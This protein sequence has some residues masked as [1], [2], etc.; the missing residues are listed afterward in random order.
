MFLRFV[1]LMR[2]EMP[3]NT[4]LDDIPI[5]DIDIVCPTGIAIDNARKEFDEL[6]TRDGYHLSLSL[7]RYIASLTMFKAI[8]KKDINDL[9][10][11]AKDVNNSYKNKI[12]NIVNKSSF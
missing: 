6:L 10:W 7:G 1:K 2:N 11:F 4:R 12:I 3:I 9:T 5:K 8:T